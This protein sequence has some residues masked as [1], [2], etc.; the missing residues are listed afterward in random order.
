MASHTSQPK[1]GRFQ[2]PPNGKSGWWDS[3]PQGASL[4]Q[5]LSLLPGPIRL[6]PDKD[7]KIQDLFAIR[8]WSSRVLSEVT[9]RHSRICDSM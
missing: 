3:N 4:R 2:A 7:K 1:G 5:I 8:L 6:H 9:S